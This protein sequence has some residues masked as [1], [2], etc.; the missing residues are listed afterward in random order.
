MLRGNPPGLLNPSGARPAS[1]FDRSN[2][3]GHRRH[4]EMALRAHAHRAGD[5]VEA[6]L[7]RGEF[8]LDGD[9]PQFDRAGRGRHE[10][11]AHVLEDVVRAFQYQVEPRTVLARTAALE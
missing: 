10:D 9:T 8:R 3:V 6:G 5:G 1:P 4:I 7:N 11:D 2:A